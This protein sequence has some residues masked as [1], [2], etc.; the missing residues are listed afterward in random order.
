M[1]K[2]LH[3]VSTFI[4]LLSIHFSYAQDLTGTI[5]GIV[6]TSDGKP[7]S[8]VDILLENTGKGA[9]VNDKGEY[10]I[11]QVKP[12]A[13]TLQVTHI[14]LVP[15]HKAINVVAGETLTVNI[16]LNENSRSLQEVTVTSGY[17]KFA[18]KETGDVARMPLKNL[19]NPQVYNVVP[20]EL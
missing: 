1:Q 17:N 3:I 13:Y 12:G 10:Q 5:K 8:Q 16:T 20:K 14:G 15:Q 4:L 11:L 2:I 9:I 18:K 19:E 7:A 6:K